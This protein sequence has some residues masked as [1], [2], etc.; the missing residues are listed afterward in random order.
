M[1]QRNTHTDIIQAFL[2]NNTLVIEKLYSDVFPMVCKL[3]YN[4][5]GNEEDAKELMQQCFLTFFKYCQKPNFILTSK[6]STFIYSI[7]YKSWMRVLQKRK[8]LAE[9]DELLEN[10]PDLVD[11]EMET[12]EINELV[13]Q[14]FKSLSADCQEIIHLKYEEE[15]SHQQIAELLDIKVGSSRL[16]LNR[17]KEKLKQRLL[18]SQHYHEILEM[19]PFLNKL[20]R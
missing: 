11:N 8:K 16:K 9:I 10:K 2:S 5:S 6:F 3:V 20:Y 7:A 18:L 17:C 12:S 13:R 4:N 14:L 19:Y 1:T 15:Q